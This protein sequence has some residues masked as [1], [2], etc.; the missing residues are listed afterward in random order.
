VPGATCR[1]DA[2]G[3]LLIDLAQGGQV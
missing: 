1:V 2:H 3:S